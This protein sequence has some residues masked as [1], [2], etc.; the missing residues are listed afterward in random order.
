MFPNAKNFEYFGKCIIII[1]KFILEILG[2]EE[3]QL[4]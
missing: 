3:E 1:K 4:S 2:F